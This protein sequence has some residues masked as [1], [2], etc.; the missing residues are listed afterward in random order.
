MLKS[1]AT[2]DPSVPARKDVTHNEADKAEEVRVRLAYMRLTFE[3]SLIIATN[4]EVFS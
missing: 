1:S 4:A 3:L 2:E